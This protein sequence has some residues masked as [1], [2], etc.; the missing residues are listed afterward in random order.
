MEL[1]KELLL[2]VTSTKKNN[3]H[4]LSKSIINSVDF[5]DNIWNCKQSDNN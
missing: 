5:S 4:N 1:K 3:K 2:V